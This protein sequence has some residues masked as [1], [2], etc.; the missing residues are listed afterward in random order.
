MEIQFIGTSAGQPA[1]NRNVSSIALKLLDEIN[2]TWLFDV[3]EATQHQIL[4]MNLKPRKVNRIFISHMHGDHVF[5]LPGFL[6]S[7]SFQGADSTEPITIYGPKG[8]REFIR[9][10][11]RYSETHLT[12]KINYVEVDEGLIFENDKFAV[13]AGKLNHKIDCWGYRVVEKDRPGE[14]LID[15]LLK[16]GVKPGPICARL[17]KGEDVE[18]DGVILKSKDFTGPARAGRIITIISDTKYTDNI[19]KLA[20][21]SDVLIHESTYGAGAEEEK[22][23]KKH[24]HSTCVQ[25]AKNA[26]NS[27]SKKLILTHISPRYQGNLDKILVKEAKKYFKD[28]VVAHDF[29]IF[30]L[31]LRK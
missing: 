19:V 10:V 24:N 20:Q 18:V 9:N 26:L 8:V 6:A 28:V 22:L 1:F 29:E 14:F 11:L 31:P 23:A 4:K 5:G 3:G 27:N 17:Q 15:K 16:T 12:Y 25:A 30:E 2:E 21:N 7:R 13:Y